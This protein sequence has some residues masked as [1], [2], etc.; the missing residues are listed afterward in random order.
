MEKLMTMTIERGIPVMFTPKQVAQILNVSRSQVY[1]LL[2]SG[3]LESVSIRGCR[4]VS[5]NQL[6][7]YIRALER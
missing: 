4:R 3:E 6:V 5:E 7:T 2:K 1:V